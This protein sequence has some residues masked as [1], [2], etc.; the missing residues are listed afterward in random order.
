MI[1]HAWNRNHFGHAVEPEA[2][3]LLRGGLADSCPDGDADADTAEI[4]RMIELSGMISL[5]CGLLVA[6]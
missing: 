6:E 5:E 3:H 1:V 4:C 2:L